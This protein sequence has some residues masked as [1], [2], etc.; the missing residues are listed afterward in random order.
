M[1]IRIFPCYTG[2]CIS[3]QITGSKKLRSSE[4]T[5]LVIFSMAPLF[6]QI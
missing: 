5:L 6:L 3:L 1:D 4:S 2:V